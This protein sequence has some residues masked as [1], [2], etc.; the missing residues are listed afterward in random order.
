[1]GPGGSGNWDIYFANA[2][3]NL[4]IAGTIDTYPKMKS[5]QAGPTT[6]NSTFYVFP[7]T[8]AIP[9]KTFTTGYDIWMFNRSSTNGQYSNLPA[10]AHFYSF[11]CKQGSTVIRNLVPAKR[12]SDNVAGIYDL[13]ND[14]FYTSMTGT[15]FV[16][17][18]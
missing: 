6:N 3:N 16:A 8:L 14:V 1:M 12:N 11:R 9:K 7:D 10:V 18:N 4:K 2:Q 17:V 13:A 15:D 5:C